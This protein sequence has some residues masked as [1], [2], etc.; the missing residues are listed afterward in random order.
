MSMLFV[1]LS[2]DSQPTYL[3]SC[4]S[5]FLLIY[6]PT[7]LPDAYPH[8]HHPFSPFLPLMTNQVNVNVNDIISSSKTKK[9]VD[10]SRQPTEEEDDDDDTV[11]MFVGNVAGDP[12]PLYP[13][14]MHSIYPCN[15]QFPLPPPLPYPPPSLSRR[16]TR[17]I[18]I[19]IDKP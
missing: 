11:V 17:S 18:Q 10:S 7:Y 2:I 9:T 15:C 4:L 14:P 8:Y 5:T 3:P 13:S 16:S 1:C 6:L 19:P 12:S